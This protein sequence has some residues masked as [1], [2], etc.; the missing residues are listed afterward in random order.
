MKTLRVSVLALLAFFCVLPVFAQKSAQESSKSGEA[1]SEYYYVNVPLE[2]VYPHRLGYMVTYRKGGSQISR[3]YL[4]QKW[5][6]RAGE[7]GEI[8]KLDGG[9]D[10]PYLIV[11]YKNGAF[12]HVRLFVRNSFSHPS[13]GSLPAGVPGDEKFDV[14]ELKLD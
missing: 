5:F 14:E 1:W 6:S 12:S 4:P 11:Y 7:K 13:W 10:W 3:A 2:K 8:I 9:A